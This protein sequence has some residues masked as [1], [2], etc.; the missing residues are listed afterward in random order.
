MMMTL[1]MLVVCIYIMIRGFYDV[2]DTYFTH[3]HKC[4]KD[5]IET[6]H[7]RKLLVNIYVRKVSH[8]SY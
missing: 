2:K 4:T 3:L 8:R 6:A 7:S 5:V 1:A